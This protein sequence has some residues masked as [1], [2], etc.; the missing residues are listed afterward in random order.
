MPLPPANAQYVRAAFA[1]GVRKKRPVG[2]STSSL[3]PTRSAAAE[4]TGHAAALVQP[5]ADAQM[6]LVGRAADR[7]RAPHFLA[8]DRRAHADVLPG[9]EAE[10]VAQLVRHVERHAD[11]LAPLRAALRQSSTDDK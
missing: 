4:V 10:R 1:S 5:H 6:A 9:R 2:G 11:G 8:V 7:I 3:S